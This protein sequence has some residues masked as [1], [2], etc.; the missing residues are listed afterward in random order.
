[1]I[2][3]GLL[4]GGRYWLSSLI[5]GGVFAVVGVGLLMRGRKGLR[6]DT[7]KPELAIQSLRDDSRWARAEISEL[8][9]DLASPSSGEK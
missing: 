6:T 9:E 4:L 3:L 1:V 2:A 7:L 8:R 5:V